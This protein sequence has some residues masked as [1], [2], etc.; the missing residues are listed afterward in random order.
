[1]TTRKPKPKPRAKRLPVFGEREIIVVRLS[2]TSAK[3]VRGYAFE[4]DLTVQ[5]LLLE[6]LSKRLGMHL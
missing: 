3:A 6:V 5:D 2:P 4:H 1:M